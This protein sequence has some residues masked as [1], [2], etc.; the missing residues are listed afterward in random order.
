MTMSHNYISYEL[1]HINKLI[2]NPYTGFW[3]VHQI[4]LY[5]FLKTLQGTEVIIL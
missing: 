5:K 1:L 2:D 3:N 4:L